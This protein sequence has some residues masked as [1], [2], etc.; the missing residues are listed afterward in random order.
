MLRT[1]PHH[2]TTAVQMAEVPLME[3]QAVAA[4]AKSLALA[5][6]SPQPLGSFRSLTSQ[7]VFLHRYRGDNGGCLVGFCEVCE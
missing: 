1:P 4:V 7:C 2:P 3:T 6:N 5:L